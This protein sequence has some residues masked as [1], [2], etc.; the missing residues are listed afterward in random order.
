MV[1][2]LSA[3]FCVRYIM[4]VHA[5][6]YL[7]LVGLVQPARLSE[8]GPWSVHSRCKWL[9]P[10]LG[11]EKARGTVLILFVI[12]IWL[13]VWSQ[14]AYDQSMVVIPVPGSRKSLV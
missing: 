9:D 10:T 8:S 3:N 6:V 2:G 11:V 1:K 14:Y 13:L 12:T 4:C 5:R 7:P